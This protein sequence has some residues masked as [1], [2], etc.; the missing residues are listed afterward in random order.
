MI[1]CQSCGS[2]NVQRFSIVFAGG[3]SEIN[4]KESG[5]GIG[6]GSGGLGIGLGSSK[7]EGNNQSLLSKKAA[8]PAKKK[9]FKH[10]LYWGIGLFI[11][12]ALFVNLMEWNSSFA[13]AMIL[14][15]Y[16]AVAGLHLYS[17]FQYNRKIFPGL[18]S[19]WEETFL[20]LKCGAE[21]RI[22]DARIGSG[23]N[24]LGAA[25]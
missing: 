5:V 1:H 18:L 17:N 10:F 12:P 7:I 16:L 2:E 23:S 9:T 4:A 6:L 21:F 19:R 13:Q 8:P 15:V 3:A 24:A 14:L 11:L 22:P 25:S 20:C